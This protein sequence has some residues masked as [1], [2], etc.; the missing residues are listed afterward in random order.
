MVVNPTYISVPNFGASADI[1]EPDS[2]NPYIDGYLPNQ[3]W[4]A[5]HAN[6]FLNG[7]TNNLNDA[8]DTISDT[9]TEINNVL[10]SAA[11]TPSGSVT[12][13]LLQS[14]QQSS[15]GLLW[16][17]DCRVATTANITLSGAQTIDGVS[18]VA[19]DRV[20]V[21]NQSTGADN[22]V[23]VCASGAWTRATDLD[24]SAEMVN[25]VAVRITAGSTNINTSWVLVTGGTITLGS[26]AL[27][28]QAAPQPGIN[29]VVPVS[30]TYTSAILSRDTQFQLDGLTGTL[31]ISAGATAKGTKVTCVVSNLA[32]SSVG[33]TLTHSAT[34][35]AYT[36]FNGTYVFAWNGTQWVWQSA[37]PIGELAQFAGRSLPT[38]FVAADGTALSRAAYADLFN[39]LVPNLGTVTI[40]IASPGVVTL[41]GHGFITGDSMYLTTTGALPTGL[42]ANTL[43]YVIFVS[44]STFRLATTYANAI[45]GTAINT[46]GTQSGTHTAFACPFRS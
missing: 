8:I 26:T 40:T 35:Q 7:L 32:Y 17:Q 41:S 31:D 2:P 16:R 25:G 33:V 30:L 46:S 22:G 38:G 37:P 28:F 10:S 9:V 12:N 1:V 5:Q 19:G 4:P 45:A 39:Y 13:Q 36:L 3:Q 34:L 11:I 29:I 43:Y 6:F 21:K 44:S 14:I 20:L 23:Y 18:V 27:V 24:A 15:G 42:S